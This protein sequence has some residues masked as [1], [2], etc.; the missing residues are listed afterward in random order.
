M[1]T[2]EE[3]QAIIQ[4]ARGGNVQN[5]LRYFG[6]FAPTGPVSS[7]VPLLTTAASAPLGLAATA[8]AMGARVAATKIR[9]SDVNKLAALMRAGAKKPKKNLGAINE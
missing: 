9:K 6:K 2:P 8:G 7:I 3:Q 4:A 1:F 5:L